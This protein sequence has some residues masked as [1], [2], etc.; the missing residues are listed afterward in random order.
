MHLKRLFWFLIP[1]LALWAGEDSGASSDPDNTNPEK[2]KGGDGAGGEEKRTFTQSELN[3]LF[4]E[5][6]KQAKQSGI[7]ELLKE[8]GAENA[9]AAKTA[10]AEAEKARKAQMSELEK[11][12]AEVA[13][14]KA[15]H[16]AAEKEKAD[17]T[18][19]AAEK[20]LR[21]A[22]LAEAT[23]Q[24]FNDPNDAWLYVDRTAIKA[25]D[26]DIFEGIDKAIEAVVKAKPYLAKGQTQKGDGKGTPD[27]QQKPG[28]QQKNQDQDE[29]RPVVNF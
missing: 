23:R 11:A 14:Y 12:Q 6:A 19:R 10:L 28:Q 9:E 8:L 26:D 15:K 21:A 24:G 4:A 29:Q 13:D 27:R 7:A 18:A 1:T 25:K 3:A 16:E 5:R 20:L 17:I 2:D 22:V